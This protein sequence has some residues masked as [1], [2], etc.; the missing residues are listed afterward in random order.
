[1]KKSFDSPLLLISSSPNDK[2][3]NFQ[4]F[5][6]LFWFTVD[7]ADLSNGIY[8]VL[9]SE[10]RLN[11][12][13]ISV[14]SSLSSLLLWILSFWSLIVTRALQ[15]TLA[16]LAIQNS[17]HGHRIVLLDI[18]GISCLPPLFTEWLKTRGGKAGS[19]WKSSRY[20]QIPQK[21]KSP[22]ALISGWLKTGGKAGRGEGWKTATCNSTDQQRF[23]LS[24]QHARA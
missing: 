21:K 20:E 7:H 24:W 19:S 14:F 5:R 15:P 2:K 22:A 9:L 6:I 12:N 4:F 13:P 16:V 1:M 8:R 10:N 11:P 17:Q 23:Q 18:S 3:W